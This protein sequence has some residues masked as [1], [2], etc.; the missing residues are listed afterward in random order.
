MKK[1]KI[2]CIVFIICVIALCIL[3][4]YSLFFNK[5]DST[6]RILVTGNA[7]SYKYDVVYGHQVIYIYGDGVIISGNAQTDTDIIVDSQINNLS[8]TELKQD[9]HRIVI[10]I[11]DNVKQCEIEFSG[12]NH[13]CAIYSE[14]KISMKCRSIDDYVDFSAGIFSEKDLQLK[15]G[16]IKT[17]YVISYE[18][19]DISGENLLSVQ[20][21][22]HEGESYE[23]AE[24]EFWWSRIEAGTLSIN[25][26]GRGKV[27]VY[28]GEYEPVFAD[29]ILLLG[30]TKL[31]YPING[32][33]FETYICE[34]N[35]K[36]AENVIFEFCPID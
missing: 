24:D 6:D 23:T 3:C 18:T 8:I 13:L 10:H 34:E 28:G 31:T 32:K 11:S 12:N 7:T 27:E 22:K 15:G 2:I 20:E 1:N 35:G 26:E 25:L 29:K 14:S 30:D 19:I 17:G 5:S 9:D 16:C 36:D 4:I 33:I 21:S